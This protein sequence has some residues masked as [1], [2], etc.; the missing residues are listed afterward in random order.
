[1]NEHAVIYDAMSTWI[2]WKA[3]V[4]QGVRKERSFERPVHQDGTMPPLPANWITAQDY[5]V[6][7]VRATTP[8]IASENGATSRPPNLKKPSESPKTWPTVYQAV[9]DVYSTLG[10]SAITHNIAIVSA[11]NQ[12]RLDEGLVPREEYQHMEAILREIRENH[13]ANADTIIT[14]Y[15][16]AFFR[17]SD[18]DEPEDTG[19]PA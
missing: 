7:G 15:L 5:W 4:I 13:L 2:P 17:L 6:N 12:K 10:H 11:A 3:Y 16:D 1:M 18:F 19:G 8:P 14:W 9:A